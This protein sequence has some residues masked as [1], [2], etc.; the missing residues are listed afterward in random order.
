MIPI[1]VGSIASLITRDGM[2][3]FELLRQP[4]LAP[5]EWLFPIVW[6]LLYFL[7]GV[8]SYWI[9]RA[10]APKEQKEKAILLYEYQLAVNFLWPTFFFHFEWYLFSFLW[11][12][13]LWILVL[14]MILQFGHID[15]KAAWINIPYLLWLSFAGY[16]NLAIWWLN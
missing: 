10:D 9:M 7:M 2:A 11:L 4:A 15:K 13:F 12:V 3:S 14:R 5:P 8:S 16:L 6:T 1:T